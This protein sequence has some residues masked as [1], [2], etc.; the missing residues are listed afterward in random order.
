MSSDQS[1]DVRRT[2]SPPARRGGRDELHW[3]E[4]FKDRVAE[5]LKS[6]LQDDMD[7]CTSFAILDL[8]NE[9]QRVEAKR[10]QDHASESRSPSRVKEEQ[11][12]DPARS[13]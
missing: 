10:D 2:P 5:D 3:V 7:W 1:K 6:V 11:T 8:L 13:A 9:L 12:S 4:V